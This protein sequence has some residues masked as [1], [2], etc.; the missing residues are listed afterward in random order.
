MHNSRYIN[1]YVGA[2]ISEDYCLMKKQFSFS[3]QFYLQGSNV[4]YSGKS[5]PKFWR[6]IKPLSSGLKSK[7]KALSNKSVDFH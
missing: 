6:N 4:V 5:Q 2:E 7:H 3:K 1:I